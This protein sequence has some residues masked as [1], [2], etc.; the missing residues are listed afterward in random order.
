M[1]EAELRSLADANLA[2]SF[3]EQARRLAPFVIEEREQGLFVAA[4]TRFPAGPA[5]CVIPND[6][7]FEPAMLVE[8]AQLFFG[9]LGR[10]FTVYAPAHFGPGLSRYCEASQWPQLADSPGMVL[11]ERTVQPALADGVELQTVE[12]PAQAD[13]FVELSALSFESI[14]VPPKVTHKLF[15]QRDRWRKPYV[16][17][18][19]VYEHGRP[20]A[21]AL[22]LLSHGIAG[23]YWV[24]TRPDARGRGYGSLITHAVGNAAFDRGARC[25]VLQATTF[26]ERVYRKLGYREFTRY[27]WYLVPGP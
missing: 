22:A 13:Q 19:I 17:A 18:Q 2:E 24:S 23:I 12:T 27:P 14:G 21:S 25:V 5:N 11:S 16:H 26:G 3:R 4:G 9:R 6:P 7:H 15:S 10:G 1:D 20:V 8:S